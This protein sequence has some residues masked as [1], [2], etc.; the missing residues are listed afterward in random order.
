MKYRKKLAKRV[1]AWL[2]LGLFGME[3]ALAVAAPI[4][5]DTNAPA[6]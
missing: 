1:T 3:S 2:V 5:P 6:S 4:L